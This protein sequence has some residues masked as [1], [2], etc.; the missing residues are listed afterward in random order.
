MKN[1][2]LSV[3]VRP[4]LRVLRG[5]L[6][7]VLGTELRKVLSGLGRDEGVACM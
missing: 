5:S 1:Q 3:S 6:D 4:L 7:A 2:E